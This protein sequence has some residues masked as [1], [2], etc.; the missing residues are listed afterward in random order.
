MVLR[1]ITNPGSSIFIAGA[2]KRIFSLEIIITRLQASSF[3]NAFNISIEPRFV[4]KNSGVQRRLLL[5][6]IISGAGASALS[7]GAKA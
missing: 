2:V 1:H 3:Q 4:N 5:I 6:K 7:A